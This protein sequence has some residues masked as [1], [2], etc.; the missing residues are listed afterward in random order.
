MVLTKQTYNNQDVLK[1]LNDEHKKPQ[2]INLTN[3][4][5]HDL[6]ASYYI[7]PGNVYS[8]KKPQLLEPHMLSM[9][10]HSFIPI[11]PLCTVSIKKLKSFPSH[12]GP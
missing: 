2:K 5:N 10:L 12:K 11:Y 1:K 8:N 9:W 7:R 3:Q 6:V 4:T